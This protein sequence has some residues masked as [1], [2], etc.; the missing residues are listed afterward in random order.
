MHQY[1]YICEILCEDRW[2]VI[3][4]KLIFKSVKHYFCIYGQID[5]LFKIWLLL[6]NRRI[7]KELWEVQTLQSIVTLLSLGEHLEVTVDYPPWMGFLVSC[8][9]SSSTIGPLCSPDTLITNEAID[10]TLSD[11]WIKFF[12]WNSLVIFLKEVSDMISKIHI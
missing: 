7:V 2:N 9:G 1:I 6:P 4:I 12:Q 10:L 5:I 8:K 3:F 11:L